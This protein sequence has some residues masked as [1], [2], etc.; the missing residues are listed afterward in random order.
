[1]QYQFYLPDIDAHS[2]IEQN[3]VSNVQFD[4]RLKYSTKLQSVDF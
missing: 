4:H 2:P 3:I 1:M